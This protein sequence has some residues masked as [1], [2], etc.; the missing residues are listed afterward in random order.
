MVQH[1]QGFRDSRR[2]YS[3]HKVPYELYQNLQVNAS[4]TMQVNEPNVS[5]NQEYEWTGGCPHRNLFSLD[6]FILVNGSETF[7]WIGP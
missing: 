4:K 6:L 7:F 3:Y 2:I 1:Y 5:L